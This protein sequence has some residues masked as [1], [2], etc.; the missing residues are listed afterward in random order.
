[1]LSEVKTKKYR[2]IK[3]G[4]KMLNSG[5]LNPLVRGPRSPAPAPLN[6][7]LGDT[8]DTNLNFSAEIISE[9]S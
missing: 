3:Q 2:K 1:M 4:P 8:S 6:L 7:H 9:F 5:P